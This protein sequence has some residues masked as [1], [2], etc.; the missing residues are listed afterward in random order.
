MPAD[1]DPHA[2]GSGT[3]TLPHTWR[4]LGTRLAGLFFFG[5]LVLVSALAWIS[6]GDLR[7]RFS[8]ASTA[9]V[10][11]IYL[12]L[13]LVVHSLVRCR[14]VA[15]QG[16]LT[17]VNGYRTHRFAWPELVTVTMP[18]GA[19]WAVLDLADG[20]AVG[21]LAVQASDGDRARDAV[22]ALRAL[23]ERQSSVG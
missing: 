21:L 2:P 11:L 1:S 9:I 12:A 5:L 8:T 4:P 18:E 16:T 3:V 22:R 23:I 17:V 13:A 19:P 7:G 6:L 14:V 10:L 20:T 15:D